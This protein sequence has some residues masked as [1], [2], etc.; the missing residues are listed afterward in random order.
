MCF[1]VTKSSASER[2]IK[3]HECSCL[4]QLSVKYLV[5]IKVVR[6]ATNEQFMGGIRNN[7][8]DHT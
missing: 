7:S 6:Q 2:K 8:G 5:I 4:K 1:S 3:Y